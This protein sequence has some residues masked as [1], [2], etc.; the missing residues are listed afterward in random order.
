MEIIHYKEIDS[1]NKEARKFLHRAPICIVAQS[2]TGGQGR[3]GKKFWSPKG[4]LYMTLVT[5]ADAFDCDIITGVVAERLLKVI[6]NGTIKG[7]NDI[8][9]D[10]KKVAGILVEKISDH[11]LIGIGINLHQT[12]PMPDELKDIVGFLNIDLDVDKVIKAI[13]A[14][15]EF[16]VTPL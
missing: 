16:R 8:M 15:G 3:F 14:Q 1:T 12:E 2:Q 9:V 4:G 13:L 5:K 11:F 6:K 10:G 7:I